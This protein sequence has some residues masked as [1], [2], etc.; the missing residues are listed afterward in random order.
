[1]KK[2]DVLLLAHLREN[3]RVPLTEL[4]RKTRLP[5]SSI[6]DRIRQYSDGLMPRMSAMI[7]FRKLGFSTDAHVFLKAEKDRK[8]ELMARL[9]SCPFVNS[10]F[11]VNNGWDF[12]VECVFRDMCACEEFIESMESLIANKE[13]HYVLDELK[14]E[15]FLADPTF[16]E[17]IFDSAKL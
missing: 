12:M 17:A 6:H 10:C 11:K 16:A 3:S 5:V 15:A 8:D 2:K 9:L 1:M 7:S 4:S 14:R 13:V